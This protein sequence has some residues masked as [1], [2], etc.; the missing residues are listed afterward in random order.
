MKIVRKIIILNLIVKYVK[1]VEV[2]IINMSM[3]VRMIFVKITVYN[4]YVH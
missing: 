3:G 2:L 4:K 1:F